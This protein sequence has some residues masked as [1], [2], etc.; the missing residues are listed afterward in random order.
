MPMSS[1]SG[2]QIV[3]LLLRLN[4]GDPEARN[5]LIEHCREQFRRR[6]QQMLGSFPRLRGDVD[7]SDVEQELHLRLAGKLSH[8][9]VND[10]RHLWRLANLTLRRFLVDWARKKRPML[11]L[12]GEA[13][14]ALGASDSG[15][16][17]ARRLLLHEIHEWIGTLPEEKQ[18][19]FDLIFYQE[20]TQEQAGLVLG[21]S[22]KVVMRLLREVQLECIRKFGQDS[23]PV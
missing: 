6:A 10:A 2:S 17:P 9:A 11:S 12:E 15:S 8:L 4:R 23:S 19:V 3:D 16:G 1:I 5:L 18:E 13:T 14:E 21:I 20:L 22:R 7:T